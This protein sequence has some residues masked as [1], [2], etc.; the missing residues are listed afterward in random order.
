MRRFD[1]VIWDLDGTLVETR[2][3]I[4]TAV[5][6]VLA[7]RGLPQMSVAAVSQ[8]VGH[9]ARVLISG[10]LRESGI[11]HL[12]P[13]EVD[14]AYESFRIHYGAHMLDTSIPYPGIP[15][16][17]QRLHEA[18][19][20]MGVVTNKPV[21]LSRQLVEGLGIARFFS[22]LLGGDSL[23]QRKPDPAPLVH[24]KEKLGAGDRPCV[25]VGDM[26]VDLEAARAAR[27]PGAAVAWGFSSRE[28]LLAASPDLLAESPA[29]LGEWILG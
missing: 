5:N 3:D 1:A 18:T 26:I 29:L 11:K 20:A 13:P 15:E 2:G 25:M 4:A 22:A 7:D 23:P 27:M 19:V 28:K 14:R 24:M 21:G 6:L 10:C 17:L 16:L 9:G 12:D 8:H